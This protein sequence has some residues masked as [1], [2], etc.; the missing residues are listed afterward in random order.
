MSKTIDEPGYL[1]ELLDTDDITYE[2]DA[3]TMYQRA[4]VVAHVALTDE[5]INEVSEC[6]SQWG[7]VFGSRISEYDYSLARRDVLINYRTLNHEIQIKGYG[8]F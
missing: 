6:L 1:L 7:F 5:I 8:N 2:L 3:Q 4:V